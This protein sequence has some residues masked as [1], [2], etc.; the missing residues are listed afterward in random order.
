MHAFLIIG[1]TKEALERELVSRITAWHISP[2]DT[3]SMPSEGALGI[4]AVR[5]FEQAISITPVNSPAKV[6]VISNMERLT[7]DAQHALLK[8]LEEPPRDTYIIGTARTPEVLLPTIQS[9]M[10]PIKLS[11]ASVTADPEITKLLHTLFRQNPGERLKTLDPYTGSRDD[12]KIFLSSLI[13][14]AHEELT[15]PTTVP[16]DKIANLINNLLTAHRQLSVNVN[17]RLVIDNAILHIV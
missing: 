15:H 5:D 12:A 8:T 1:N 17:Q 9:R 14:A 6:G 4:D 3:I 2:W 13:I 7:V 11:D 16:Q 10:M